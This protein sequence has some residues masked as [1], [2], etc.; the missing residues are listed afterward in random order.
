MAIF[1]NAPVTKA[2][3]MLEEKDFQLWF[4]GIT[5]GRVGIGFLVSRE[6]QPT[7][8]AADGAMPCAHDFAVTDDIL[9][10][11]IHCGDYIQLSQIAIKEKDEKTT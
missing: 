10:Y 4:H 3:H 1:I 5:I 7:K 11:C 8:R 9:D 6:R 2:A